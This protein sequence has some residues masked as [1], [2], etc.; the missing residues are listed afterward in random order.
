MRYKCIAFHCQHIVHEFNPLWIAVSALCFVVEPLWITA[1]A[2]CFVVSAL[3]QA[4]DFIILK[5]I[6]NKC[7]E[8]LSK[9]QKSRPWSKMK[10]ILIFNL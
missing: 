10:P 7:T 1:N 8:K 3:L 4:F 2:L 6:K 5:Q 9:M